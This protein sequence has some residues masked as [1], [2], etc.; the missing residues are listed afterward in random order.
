MRT[1]LLNAKQSDIP[2]TMGLAG[3]DPRFVQLANA[4]QQ[5]LADAGK[6]WGT[7]GTIRTCVTAGCITWPR[8]VKT[9]LGMNVCGYGIPIRNAWYEFQLYRK[10]PSTAECNCDGTELLDRGTVCQ[11]Q[12][13]AGLSKIRIYPANSTDVGKRVLLQGKDANGD[14]IRTLD[15]S[16]WVDGEYVTLASPFIEST[17]QFAAPSLTGVQKPLTNGLL[18]VTAVNV[19]TG[20]QTEIAVW[21]PS[22]TAPA[23]RRTYLNNLPRL[24]QNYNSSRGCTDNGNGCVAPDEACTNIVVESIV[25][26]E[27]VPVVVDTDWLFISNLRA[28][29]HGM[30]SIQMR[31]REEYQK[32]EIEW[33]Q[34]L[35]LLRNELEAY[36]PITQTVINVQPFGT[37]KPARIFGG[38][39]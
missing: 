24:C 16:V 11:H 8:F 31:D 6:W 20:A 32:A 9:I 17:K 2:A 37:A 35:R 28:L 25:R 19:A 23:Y 14:T 27:F 34:A 29:K 10:A 33:Q 21:E 1:T 38:F 22:E 15:G 30:R 18:T 13:F 39:V 26:M 12:D 4:A 7:Y 3:C 36:S 5:E